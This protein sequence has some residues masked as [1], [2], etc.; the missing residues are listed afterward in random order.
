LGLILTLSVI[1][2]VVSA[3]AGFAV[4]PDPA[5]ATVELLW[6]LIP[7][8]FAICG[9]LIVRRQPG[10]AVGWVLLAP[11]LASLLWVTPVAGLD[12]PPQSVDIAIWMQIWIDNISWMLLFFPVFFLLLVFPTGRLP[13]PRWRIVVAL[14]VL[15]FVGLAALSALANPIGPL[16]ADWMVENPI[17]M[18]DTSFFEGLFPVI[19]SALLMI[20][21][22]SGVSA[23]VIR[24]R[25]GTRVEKQQ[26]KWLLL[27]VLVFGLV[28]AVPVFN[29][30]WQ[31]GLLL[32]LL[33]VV[34]LI[35]I[36][37]AILFAVTRYRL[38]EI[39]RLL[40]RTLT[41]A[42]VAGILAGFVAVVAGLVGSRFQ[43][44]WLVAATTLAVA[45]MFNPLRR[46]IQRWM[47][48]RFN[49]TRYDIAEVIAAFTNSLQVEI[50]P[51]R[52]TTGLLDVVSGTMQPASVGLWVRN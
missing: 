40:S 23:V 28:Y 24:Y 35:G 2:P 25:K 52:L 51:A 15:M 45:G 36:P 13:S 7:A 17:G 21:T 12:T 4:A 19:W 34:S 29:E 8:A 37:V 49:R 10:N 14:E 39:D 26:I 6:A 38:Y 5:V 16:E 9:A 18:L 44:P 41:Y 47:D 1:G 27:A 42:L 30:D 43:E 33:L 50:D 32:D 20:L 48:R 3:V 46:R 31:G 11:G 22:I